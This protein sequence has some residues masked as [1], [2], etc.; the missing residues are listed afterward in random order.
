[1]I[2]QLQQHKLL[3]IEAIKHRVIKKETLYS[4]GREYGV[5]VAE[6]MKANKGLTSTIKIGQ[7]IL[8]PKKISK[9]YIIHKVEYNTRVSKIAKLYRIPIFQIKDFNPTIKNVFIKIR[10]LRFLWEAMQ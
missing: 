4:I 3:K 9:P 8:V 1:M 10:K 2:A 6:L 7:I 5:T